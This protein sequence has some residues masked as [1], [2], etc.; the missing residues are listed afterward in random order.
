MNRERDDMNGDEGIEA[1][2]RHVGARR[3]PSVAAVEEV[4]RAVHQE[5][6]IAVA[7]RKRRHRLVSFAAAA[8]I[9]LVVA[10]ASWTLRFSAPNPEIAVTIARV[11]HADG[12][13][14]TPGDP[15]HAIVAG[16]PVAI[17]AVVTTDDA[18]RIALA[19]GE[20]V[21]IRIDRDTRIERTASDRFRLRTG[22]IYV[23]ALPQAQH[24][25]LVIETVAGEVRHIGTQYQVRQTNDVVEVSIREGRVEIA[26]SNG[27]ATAAAGERL[28]VTAAGQVERSEISAQDPS[29]RWAAATSPTFAIDDRTLAEFLEWVARE[30]GRHV[31]YASPDAQ[32]MAEALKLRGSIEGLEPETALSAVLATTELTQYAAGENLIGV[33]LAGDED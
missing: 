32:R 30:T 19:S 11:E 2:L 1:L 28:R 23:D 4:R 24:H 17:D 29:W 33:R 27:A 31:V 25:D 21:T 22:G 8:G 12:E 10:A 9:M 20:N 7:Q 13:Q 5:W 3:E 14:T 16:N 6:R 26:R 15:G 18:T